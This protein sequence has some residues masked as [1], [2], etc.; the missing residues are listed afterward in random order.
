MTLWKTL[1]DSQPQPPINI[2]N[3]DVQVVEMIQQGDS[4]S[5][6]VLTDTTPARGPRVKFKPVDMSTVRA[7]HFITHEDEITAPS[8]RSGE[9]RGHGPAAPPSDNYDLVG[10][11]DEPPAARR[12]GRKRIYA[13]N[14]ERQ[15]A[16][17]DRKKQKANG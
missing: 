16:L 11:I 17:R 2:V 3:G 10:D 4:S 15:K 8:I 12:V 14:A 6:K 5:T 7:E 13:T 1:K 9:T